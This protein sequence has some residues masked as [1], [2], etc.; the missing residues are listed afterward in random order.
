MI[1]ICTL[2]EKIK[3]S[4]TLKNRI[5]HF[6]FCNGRP[7]WWVKHILNPLVLHHGKAAVIRWQTIMNV[8]PINKFRLGAGSTIEEFSVIDNGVGDIIIG[9]QTRIG[10]RATIIGPVQIGDHVI[11]AQN[12]VLSGLN[13][14]YENPDCPIH[15]QGTTTAL[16]KISDDS[17][18]GANS[19]ITAGV[20]IGKHV[21]IG[22][23]SVVTKDIP[24][25]SIAVGNPARII[26]RF[27]IT[28]REWKK[29][30][31]ET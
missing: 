14:R 9:D 24:D 7:R 23:G 15:H 4:P 1:S 3:H 28:S 25:Y 27:D 10:L 12:I 8:S 19:V 20:S 22:A 13:H 17:W 2:K 16:I 11:L 30:I 18:V 26:K 29:Y 5:Y 21:I 6:I 31:E